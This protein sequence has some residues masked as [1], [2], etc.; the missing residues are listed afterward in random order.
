MIP[1]LVAKTRVKMT[2]VPLTSERKSTSALAPGMV[3]STLVARSK[4]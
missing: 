3:V 1:D 2:S 4:T